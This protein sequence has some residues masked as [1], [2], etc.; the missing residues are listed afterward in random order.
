M[1]E[2]DANRQAQA[3]L[4]SQDLNNDVKLVSTNSTKKLRH[5]RLEFLQNPII[6]FLQQDAGKLFDGHHE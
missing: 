5:R 6:L 4:L 2:L 1:S 3:E